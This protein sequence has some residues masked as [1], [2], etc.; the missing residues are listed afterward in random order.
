MFKYNNSHIFTGYLKQFLSTF[1]L[2]TC[3][4]YTHEFAKY[5]EQ[6]GAEDPRILQS[7]DNLSSDRLAVRINYL[8]NNEVYNYFWRCSAGEQDLASESN[9]I[10]WK[11]CREAYYDSSKFKPGITRTLTS[12]GRS[13]DTKT[14]E[15]LG[16]YLRFLRDYYNINLMS[17]YNCF[18]DKII[19]N[20]YFSFAL[21][22]E[23]RD[24]K[25]V[26]TFNAQDP[27]YK[28]YAIPVKLFAEYTIAIDSAQGVEL[29]CGL[30]NT[31]LDMTSNAEKLAAKTYKKVH[32]SLFHQPFLYE[33]LTLNNWLPEDD[34]AVRDGKKV[35]RTDTF[36]RWDLANREKDLRLFIKVP[37]SCRS[38]ITVLEGNYL[39]YNDFKYVPISYKADG[40]VFDPNVDEDSLKAKT[41]FEYHQNHNILNFNT[42]KVRYA[43]DEIDLNN[44][45]FKPIGK[46]QLLALNTGE[47]YPFA[48]RLVEYLSGSVITPIDEIPDNIKRTQKVMNANNT[49]FNI[50]GIWEPKMQNILYD[51]VA[52][53]GPIKTITICD[54]K[55]NELY[56]KEVN[57]AV[58]KGA[59]KQVLKDMRQGAHPRLGYVTKS[60]MYDI[61]G[62][63]DKDTEKLYASWKKGPT[64]AI[65]DTSLQ[66][67]DIYVDKNGKSLWD[68]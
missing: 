60:T 7:F 28:I 1:N 3:R 13:Y 36:T 51:Y 47:S 64:K 2:P 16:E 19:D 8:K 12:P 5:L 62:Y 55:D 39:G 6:N 65:V 61:L 68:I 56:G 15:Y 46:L 44:Y 23:A 27:G 9:N 11:R 66:S 35:I 67:V 22:P 41:V 37:V 50:D 25:I 52:N 42:T 59:T 54:D 57:P 40:T 10:T 20:V 18:N 49:Y 30:Y 48:D 32:R 33:G 53:S 43:G 29:F 58:Y 17:L 4:I 26:T 34:F 31:K 45:S 21:N 38:T 14:H 24:K 63:V